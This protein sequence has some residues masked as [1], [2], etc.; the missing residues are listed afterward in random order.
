MSSAQA[1]RAGTVVTLATKLDQVGEGAGFLYVDRDLMFHLA[2]AK[3][4]ELDSRFQFIVEKPPQKSGGNPDLAHVYDGDDI[5]LRSVGNGKYPRYATNYGG[6][7]Y[8]EF[9]SSEH[10]A[11]WNYRGEGPGSMEMFRI[12]SMDSG[13][14]RGGPV[15]M[16]G[17]HSYALVTVRSVAWLSASKEYGIKSVGAPGLKESWFIVDEQG[18]VPRPHCAPVTVYTP[19]S[20]GGGLPPVLTNYPA[21]SVSSLALTSKE[22]KELGIGVGV[23]IVLILIAIAAAFFLKKKKSSAPASSQ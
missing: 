2:E 6:R 19:S 10:D 22:K 8:W 21:G 14:Q 5:L 4:A 20:T 17:M 23:L 16:D 15:R 11:K 18:H 13:S 3:P 12:V 1:L 9:I 7:N